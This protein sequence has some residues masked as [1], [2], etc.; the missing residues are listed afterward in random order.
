M[1]CFGNVSGV[2]INKTE[3]VL[4]DPEYQLTAKDIQEW[5]KENGELPPNCVVLVQFGWANRYP[6]RVKYLG[7][8]SENDFD[9]HFPTLS[10][11]L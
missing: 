8:Q 4:K 7:L 2:L 9:R 1:Q 3:Q 6:D 11:G 10:G 5:E